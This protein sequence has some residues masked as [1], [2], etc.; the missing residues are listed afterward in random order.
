MIGNRQG[1]TE[2][3]IDLVKWPSPSDLRDAGKKGDGL[4]WTPDLRLESTPP[5]RHAEV[6]T[7]KASP[8]SI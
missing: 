2:I 4:V 3:S 8:L 7:L 6:P 5:L 1:K